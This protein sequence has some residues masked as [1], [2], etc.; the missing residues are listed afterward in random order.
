MND[1]IDRFG[2][3]VPSLLDL[4][5]IGIVAVAL[6]YVLFAAMGGRQ[7]RRDA[8]LLPLRVDLLGQ[9]RQRR[10]VEQAGER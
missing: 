9:R 2:F 5:Q 7:D 10:V 8:E 3:I 4:I 1:F 6:Y